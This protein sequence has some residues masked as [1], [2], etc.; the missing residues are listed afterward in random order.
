[1]IRKVVDDTLYVLDSDGGVVLS[2]K[3]T[4]GDGA[5]I[6]TVGG[7]MTNE[8]APEFEDELMTVL[9]IGQR[10]V[11]DFSGLAYISAP[12]LNA[13]LAAQRLTE[14]TSGGFY[15]LNLTEPVREIF[16][17]TGFIDLIDVRQ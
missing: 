9:T 16:E 4:T 8:A 17:H 5:M 7:K 10:V 1:M 13:L 2:I 12:G 15:V 6:F 3:E 14:E 11:L